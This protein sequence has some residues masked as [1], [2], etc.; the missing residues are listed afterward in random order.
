MADAGYSFTTIMEQSLFEAQP[1]EILDQIVGNLSNQS[2]LLALSFASP[3]I[4]AVIIPR[5]LPVCCFDVQNIHLLQ[6]ISASPLRLQI[7]SLE[8]VSQADTARIHLYGEPAVSLPDTDVVEHAGV[9]DI[10][11]T[12]LHEMK[13]LRSFHWNVTGI[14]PS[15]DV[16]A[17]LLSS[18]PALESV[19]IHS[20]RSYGHND[21]PDGWFLRESPLWKLSNLTSF[22]YVVS[23]QTNYY[24]MVRYVPQLVEMLFRCPMLEEL[25]LLLAHDRACDVRALFDGRWPR[26]KSLLLGGGPETLYSA[27]VPHRSKP[28]VQV[29][30]TAHP[31]LERLYLSV[32]VQKGLRPLSYPWDAVRSPAESFSIDSLP[33]LKLLHIPQNIFT[34]IAPAARMPHLEHL[35]CVEAE[36]SC[37]PLFHELTQSAANITSLW[38]GLYRKLTLPN[39][40]SFLE[41]FPRLE[42]LYIWTGPPDPWVPIVIPLPDYYRHPQ[43][44]LRRFRELARGARVS[45]DGPPSARIPPGSSHVRVI[46]T[47]FLGR[48]TTP[49]WRCATRSASSRTSRTF[50]TL[51][52]ST[53]TRDSTRWWTRL[54]ARSPRRSRGSRSSRSS[55][56]ESAPRR[57]TRAMS[58]RW[59]GPGLRFSAMR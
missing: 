5:H 55:S 11:P 24:H 14:S 33:N 59:A 40:K 8:L 34:M 47:P 52:C 3:V 25:E 51:S 20:L 54:Y 1:T 38:L 53:R 12:L 4:A 21:V 58:L 9:D 2:D 17:A 13:N 10:L 48:L 44:E 46:L 32:N 57:P 49:S 41:C 37:L 22:S 29:V 16:F 28:D 36:P 6:K 31:A 50:P 18:T 35:R 39:F 27:T 45:Y 43:R 15:T 26:L 30:F 23:S 42:K 7:F 19:K 56:Q